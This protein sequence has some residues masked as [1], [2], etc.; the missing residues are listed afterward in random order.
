MFAES[1]VEVG[2]FE[3][4][5][6]GRLDATK[7][8]EPELTLL[9]SIGADHEELLGAEPAQRL[10]EKAGV[11]PEGGKLIA[12][13]L[14]EELDEDLRKFARA[15][16]IDLTILDLPEINPEAPAYHVANEALA[17]AGAAAILGTTAPGIELTHT[18][19]RFD[20]GTVHGV[21]FIA[22]VAHNPTAWEAF[23]DAVPDGTYQGVV[24]IS[25]PRPPDELAATLA[26]HAELFDTVITT[27]LTVRPAQNPLD[28]AA[29]I[30]QQGVEAIAIA[31]PHIAFEDALD[32]CRNMGLPL[33]VLGSNYLV[34]DFL[35]WVSK[36]GQTR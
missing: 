18:E 25:A 36:V 22:D 9:T 7:T 24:S 1:G 14:G 15:R 4:G 34:V 8:L 19:G 6:G 23:L 17:R 20:C 27:N 28:L 13:S 30:S 33:L 10:H 32:R 2:I 3:A 5:I 11:V 31:D 29:A 35:A 16:E 26:R 21:P 12:S